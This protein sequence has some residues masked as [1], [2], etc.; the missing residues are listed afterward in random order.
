VQRTF[1]WVDKSLYLEA[2]QS[3][4]LDLDRVYYW[5][6]VVVRETEDSEGNVQRNPLSPSSEEW[7]FHWR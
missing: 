1:W 5:R 6:V 3:T 7:S 4:D 2:D